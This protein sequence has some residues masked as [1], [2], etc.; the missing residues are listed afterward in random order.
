MSI[1][2]ATVSNVKW[3]FIESI[4]LQVV[5]FILSLVLARLLEPSAFGVLAIVNVFYLLTTLFIDSGLKEA[6]IQKAEV[7]E[8]DYSSV[9]WLNMGKSVFIYSCLFIV[10]PYIQDSYGY[11]NL[12]FYIRLQSLTLIIEAFGLVQIV[13]AI[14]DLQIKKI[15]K[16]RIPASLISLL[17]GITMAYHGFG[18]VSLIVQQLVN[19]FIY[20]LLLVVN[21]R[22][23]PSFVFDFKLVLPLYKFGVR[24]LG[25]SLISRFYAQSL[26][27]I[28]AKAYS[29][30]TLGLYSKSTSMQNTP[31]DIING[32]FL[33]GLYPTLVK[34]QN[35]TKP[36]K[37]IVLQNIKTVT[38]L[39]LIVNGIFYFQAHEIIRLLLGVKWFGM[40][41]YVKIAAVGSTFFPINGQCQSIFKVKN[42]V[43]LF[44]KIELI[45]KIVVLVTIFSLISFYDL[46]QILWLIVIITILTSVTYFY[47]TSRIL[48][49]S[50]KKELYS[51]LF[52]MLIH[53]LAGFG[54]NFCI[55]LLFAH[56]PALFS[57]MIF[58][59]IYFVLTAFLFYVFNKKIIGNLFKNNKFLKIKIS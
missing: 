51:L 49:F 12:S 41:P 56:I 36:L 38:F 48:S 2:K 16:A 7:T 58:G 4:S 5:S 17:V 44:F 9:F 3:S 40:E 6:L 19:V 24:L 14:K 46:P 43:N 20:S 30:T 26:N 42:K 33:K 37:K 54:L 18:I 50:F 47:F 34:L 27:L 25:V 15:T 13:K 32:P 22:F 45:S 11:E 59:F 31:I 39:I 35:N 21:I 23:R 55:K 29:P 28:Y 52:L 8:V 53:A 1:K 10:A 57:I